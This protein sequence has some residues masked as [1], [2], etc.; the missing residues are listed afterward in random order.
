MGMEMKLLKW[1]GIGTKNLFL[2]TSSSDPSSSARLCRLPQGQRSG[3]EAHQQQGNVTASSCLAA[4]CEH[5]LTDRQTSVNCVNNRR[6]EP[7]LSPQNPLK[8]HCWSV[9]AGRLVGFASRHNYSETLFT[10]HDT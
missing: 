9:A 7:R 5:V 3:G 4:R 6:T 10:L 8:V 1:E 2:H